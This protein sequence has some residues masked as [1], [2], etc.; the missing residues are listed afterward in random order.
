M[1][2][3]MDTMGAMGQQGFMNNQYNQNVYQNQNNAMEIMEPA[4]IKCIG[5][6]KEKSQG[7][8]QLEDKA[9]QSQFTQ[10]NYCKKSS[11]GP[12]SR[13]CD[14][15]GRFFCKICVDVR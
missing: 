5:C 12:C 7:L 6:L 9:D 11:C 2:M 15:C 14:C 10:C 13:R 4:K 3:E 8:M 1:T